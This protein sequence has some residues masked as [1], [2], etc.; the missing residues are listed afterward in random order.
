M[1][2]R[3][4][5][6]LFS[7]LFMLI[8]ILLVNT[9]IYFLFHK[10]SADS[11]LDQLAA[12]TNTIIETLNSNPDIAINELLR[13]YLPTDGM[14]RVMDE[15]GNALTVLTKHND[16]TSLPGEYTT[17]ESQSIIVRENGLEVAAISKPLIWENGE[18]VTLQVSNHLV[19]LNE[20]MTTLFYVLVIAS[21]IMLIPTIIAGILLSR[22][23]LQPIKA[24]IQAMK[25]N[26][27]QAKWKK[28]NVQNRSHDELYEMEKTFNEMIDYLKDNFERQET[29]VSDASH[30][31]RTPISI[32]KSY[33]ELLKRQGKDN[34]D[35]F[36]ESVEAIDTEVERMQKL[37][38]QMLTLAKNKTT[39]VIQV[40]DLIALSEHTI[41]TFRG[42][43][44]RKISVD[45]HG[46]SLLVNGNKDQLQQI[47][48]ILIDNAIKYSSDE[49]R[50]SIAQQK[51]K[52]IMKVTDFGQGISKI[53]H[54]RI[55][56]RF[57][58][59]D[60]AR[61]RDTGGTGL[62]LAIAKSIAETH[63]GDLCVTSKLG[64]GSTFTLSLPIVR[65]S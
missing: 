37:V 16:Y 12:Q 36:N 61:S 4:K 1:K 31:L 39:D 48:Y 59:I 56:D 40:V 46:D 43:Y 27:K 51:N 50:I 38:E 45:N 28:I 24:L 62:G 23:L 30:E 58:R 5:I 7:S 44:A 11:E 55:F 13:A 29:F 60:K 18:I 3:T 35:L 33:G 64:E 42:A 65:E 8:L 22:F 20:T 47:I 52:A 15:D 21:V 2:L 14:I 19:A 17:T 26:T 34:H 10:V 25:E 32:V 6:Q 63:H 49:I 54:A 9:S 53:D 57:Y 41:T